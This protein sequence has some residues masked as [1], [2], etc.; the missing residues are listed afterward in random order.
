M[1]RPST[2]SADEIQIMT[3]MRAN[4]ATIAAIARRLKRSVSAIRQKVRYSG[5]Q[6]QKAKRCGKIVA[7]RIDERLHHH[8]MAICKRNN[9]TSYAFIQE[10]IN[11][12]I[13]ND[14]HTYS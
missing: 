11:R 5:I 1:S 4:G 2:Y 6:R 12:E 13:N 10:L 7:T 14:P 3:E 9:M 8:W